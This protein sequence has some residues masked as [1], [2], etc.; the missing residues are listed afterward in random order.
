MADLAVTEAEAAWARWAI[1]PMGDY[2]EEQV[3]DGTCA[4]PPELPV[5]TG[6]VLTMPADADVMRDFLYRLEVRAV[7]MIADA[8]RD[9]LIHSRDRAHRT[10]A[11]KL[12]RLR[13]DGEVAA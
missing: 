1:D 11:Q 12:R 7:D 9:G 4:T 3:E 10:L 8:A 5:L 6:L 13:V 2:W